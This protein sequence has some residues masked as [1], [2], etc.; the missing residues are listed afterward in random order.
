MGRAKL[1]IAKIENTS[2]RQSTFKKRRVG[3]MKKAHELSILCDDEIA[4][5][6]FSSNGKL[7]EFASSSME[8][9]LARF[10]KSVESKNSTIEHKILGKD[11]SEVECLKQDIAD[12]Q[13]KNMQLLRK[14]LTG[15]GL[16]EFQELEQQFNEGLLSIKD[17]KEQ[18]LI[19]ELDLSRKKEQEFIRENATLRRKI[20]RLQSFFPLNAFPESGYLEREF[21]RN[22]HEVPRKLSP[23][24]QA[25]SSQDTECQTEAETG[26]LMTTLFLGPPPDNRQR[27]RKTPEKDTGTPSGTSDSHIE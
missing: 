23:R 24:R 6:V 16:K 20:E 26:E 21:P 25:S 7:F 10:N 22:E 9:T 17:K 27:K 19:E 18:L 13:L 5:I 8:H 4:V 14:D 3:L 1:E 2:S 15:L 11:V 12:L